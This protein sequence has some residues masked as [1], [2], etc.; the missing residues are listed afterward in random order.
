MEVN[1][2]AKLVTTSSMADA[3]SVAEHEGGL[4]GQKFRSNIGK[5][6]TEKEMEEM[7]R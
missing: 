2:P 1:S 4:D 3:K 6:A 5:E 7:V